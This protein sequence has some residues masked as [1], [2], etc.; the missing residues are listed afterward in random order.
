VRAA[1]ERVRAALEALGLER[2]VITLDVHARTSQQAAEALGV[3][4]GQIVKSLVF[5]AEGGEAVLVLASGANRVDERRLA[6]LVGARVRRADPEAVKRVTGYAIG[7]VPPVGHAQAL[8][9]FVDEDLLGYPELYAAA[10]VP[11]CVFPLTP[12][13]LVRG[14]GGR[15]CDVKVRGQA[16]GG[17]A[18]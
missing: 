5:T 6:E 11:E 7:G 12:A 10:G 4:V 13:E 15:V 2:E 8:P 14:T 16:P 17:G 18:A 1:A 9:V 3:S